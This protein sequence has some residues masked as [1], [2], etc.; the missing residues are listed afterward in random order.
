MKLTIVNPPQLVSPTNYVSSVAIPP[1]G[2]AYIAAALEEAGHEVHTVDAVGFGL[3]HFRP[4]WRY[5]LRGLSHERIIERIPS[6]AADVICLGCNFSCQW[7]STRELIND[8]RTAFPEAVIV[9]GGEHA[10]AMPEFSLQESETDICVLGE[11]EVTAAELP[12]IMIR[13]I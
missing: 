10:T 5:H 12:V 3:Q 6:D 13:F 4:L 1:L 8:I 9:L 7:P 2:L 11:G